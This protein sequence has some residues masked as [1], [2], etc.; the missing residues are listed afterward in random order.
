MPHSYNTP[1]KYASSPQGAFSDVTASAETAF[2]LSYQTPHQS[3]DQMPLRD[4]SPE[5]C[6]ADMLLGDII[7]DEEEDAVKGNALSMSFLDALLPPLDA[8]LA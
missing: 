1:A 6:I 7:S 5:N 3:T 4:V 8:T 2:D